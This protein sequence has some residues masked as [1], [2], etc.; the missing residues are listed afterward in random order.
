VFSALRDNALEQI[1]VARLLIK[2]HNDLIP[3]VSAE[4]ASQI[5]VYAAASCVT[6]VYAIYENFFESL[7]SDY[8][9]SVAEIT[10]YPDLPEALR[11]EYLVGVSH[12][13]GK[14]D[15]ERYRHLT[16][17]NIILWYHEAISANESYRF[18]TEAL[19]RHERNLRLDMLFELTN[20]VRLSRLK[21]W[22]EGCGHI[23]KLYDGPPTLPQLEAEL[24]NFVQ[25]RND[26]AHGI[27]EDLEGTVTLERYCDLISAIV[28]SLCGFVSAGLLTQ[29]VTAGKSK[30][31][32]RITE[33]FPKSNACVAVV[34][35][36]TMVSTGISV[37]LLRPTS[38]EYLA[39][40]SLMI[41]G[42]PTENFATTNTSAEAGFSFAQLPKRGTDI[43]IDV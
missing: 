13:L 21:E 15:Q 43:Y 24:R 19:T 10:P 27:I 23:G 28:N 36:H 30:K 7:L 29:R 14:I 26:A 2:F 25:M 20:R 33:V 6:R 39:V 37:H 22:I 42:S 40:A 35:P 16:H 17:E 12:I 9:D 32:A 41:N 1:E 38:Y 3:T 4:R 11:N 5:K 31:A 8:L 18:I 34:E